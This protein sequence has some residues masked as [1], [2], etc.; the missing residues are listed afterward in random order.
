EHEVKL[1]FDRDVTFSGVNP[2]SA[3]RYNF[4]NANIS[5]NSNRRKKFNYNAKVD[6][7]SYYRGNRLNIDAGIN[8]RVQPWGKF[9]MNF[10]HNEFFMPDDIGDASLTLIGP[11]IDITFTTNLYFTTFIQYNKQFDNMNINSRI[12]WRFNPMSDI[13]FVYTDNYTT[14]FGIKNRAMVLKFVY[15]L[16]V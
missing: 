9:S 5:Y 4:Y 13:F 1:F 2:H 14:D 16:N 6:Y 3:G 15:W 12:Q 10:T 11:K 8:Y 7:G